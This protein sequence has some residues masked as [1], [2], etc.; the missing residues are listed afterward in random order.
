LRCE[1]V[2][3]PDD[4]YCRQVLAGDVKENNVVV[5]IA[6]GVCTEVTGLPEGWTY[7]VEDED[8]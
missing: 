1:C 7:T 8:I 5:H 3:H 2:D 4:E 6:G